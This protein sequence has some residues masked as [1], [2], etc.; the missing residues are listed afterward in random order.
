MEA[1]GL[2]APLYTREHDEP[3][4]LLKEQISIAGEHDIYH[5]IGV[6]ALSNERARAQGQVVFFVRAAKSVTYPG[7]D[8]HVM[9]SMIIDRN[10]VDEWMKENPR[11]GLE[12]NPGRD[13]PPEVGPARS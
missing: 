6:P 3:I 2:T 10:N 7:V 1:L 5:S 13:R 4:T 11:S 12:P 9:A 8:C